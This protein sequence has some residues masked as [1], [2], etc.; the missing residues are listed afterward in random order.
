MQ[1]VNCIWSLDHLLG[2]WPDDPYD[3]QILETLPPP[4]ARRLSPL[5]RKA[6]Q[7]VYKSISNLENKSIPWIVA[8]RH[9]DISRR[10]KLLT[11]LA[12]EETLSPT[13]FSLSVHNAIIAMFSIASGNKQT[14]TA[15]A[16]GVNSFESGLIESIALLHAQGGTVG[17]LYYDFIEADKWMDPL[18]ATQIHCFTMIISQSS[19]QLNLEYIPSSKTQMLNEFNLLDLCSY[20]NS[21]QK[22]HRIPVGGGEI[23]FLRTSSNA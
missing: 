17:F 4:L 3:Q 16:A 6:L 14:H 22:K 10:L 2:I 23:L 15:L 20:L 12:Q 19:G 13:D 9:G 18:E 8:C 1:I 7:I 21:N 5:G 11:D